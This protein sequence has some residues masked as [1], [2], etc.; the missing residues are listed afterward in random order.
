MDDNQT[1]KAVALFPRVYTTPKEW[2][3]QILAFIQRNQLDV[4]KKTDNH[5]QM[6]HFIQIITP[7][8]PTNT[9]KLDP[10][11]YEK[12]L[13]TYLMQKKYEVNKKRK[14]ERKVQFNLFIIYQ[15]LKDLLQQWPIN[16]YNLNSIDQQ[17]RLQMNDENTEKALL[18]CS[19]MM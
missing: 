16:I 13:N 9:P 14:K 6:N 3:E 5:T 2:E 1:E 4:S 17:I 18:E 7:Y 10:A 8:I 19:A 11:I 15:K 12:V